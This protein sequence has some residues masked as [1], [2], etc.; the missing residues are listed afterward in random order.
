MLRSVDMERR[1][2]REIFKIAMS[3]RS[4]GVPYMRAACPS[5]DII[6]SNAVIDP[7]I[8]SF[9]QNVDD[10]VG[11]VIWDCGLLLVDCVLYM[12]RERIVPSDKSDDNPNDQNSDDRPSSWHVLDLGTGT[13]VAGIVACLNGIGKT[14]LTDYKEYDVMKDNVG[15][16]CSP[17]SSIDFV[18]YSWGE[19]LPPQW[20]R[21]GR[22]DESSAS[23]ELVLAGDILYNSKCHAELERTIRLLSFKRMLITYKRRHD[24]V[25]SSLLEKLESDFVIEE[26]ICL[27]QGYY[28]NFSRV[29]NKE[30]LHVLELTRR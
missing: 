5:I 28:Q 27:D 6:S 30:G 22:S 18:E 11:G 24:D 3:S 19:R 13:G 29:E 25:E 9:A 16:H 4:T 7:L 21:D 10:D 23:F 26:V 8:L 12:L 20:S 14:T 1:N 2:W 17:M 15:R